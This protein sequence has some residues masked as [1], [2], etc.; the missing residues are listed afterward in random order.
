MTDAQDFATRR[1]NHR[2]RQPRPEDY[3]LLLVAAHILAALFQL[4]SPFEELFLGLAYA[5]AWVAH[6][7]PVTDWETHPVL[8]RLV[9]KHLR[10]APPTQ[11]PAGREAQDDALRDSEALEPDDDTAK[12][13]NDPTTASGRSK[14]T[15]DPRQP[16]DSGASDSASQ[17]RAARHRASPVAARSDAAGAGPGRS[18]P[19]H[20]CL[21]DKS[22]HPAPVL[23]G[24]AA[25]I[26][27]LRIDRPR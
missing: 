10:F 17:G 18:S 22:R 4:H 27:N 15:L 16:T 13:M 23:C 7:I 1:V 20:V 8:R 5:L 2:G 26:P 24:I 21:T 25:T 6:R 11:Q 19:P 12:A 3:L 14:T 9:P